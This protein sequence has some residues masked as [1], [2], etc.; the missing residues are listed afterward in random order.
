[1]LLLL[2]AILLSYLF[3]SPLCSSRLASQVLCFLLSLL[4]LFPCQPLGNSSLGHV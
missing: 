2:T 1:M 3:G 4:L